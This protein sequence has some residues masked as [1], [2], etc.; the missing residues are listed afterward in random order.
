MAVDGEQLMWTNQLT[1]ITI[2]SA[3]AALVVDHDPMTDI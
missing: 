3:R 2:P 1:T